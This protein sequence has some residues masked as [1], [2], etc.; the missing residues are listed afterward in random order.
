MMLF[1][2]RLTHTHTHR[3]WAKSLTTG[4]GVENRNIAHKSAPRLRN[5]VHRWDEDELELLEDQDSED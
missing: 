4:Y 1:I 2:S 3:N 5:F